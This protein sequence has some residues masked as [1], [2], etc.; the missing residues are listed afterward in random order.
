MLNIIFIQINY[1]GDLVNMTDSK[2]ADGNSALLAF[3]YEK[4]FRAESYF[5]RLKPS[6]FD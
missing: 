1:T 2:L 3:L 6:V 4:L 5:P